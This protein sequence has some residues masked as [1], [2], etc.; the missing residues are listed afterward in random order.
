MN[1]DRFLKK[2]FIEIPDLG[3]DPARILV[4]HGGRGF[5]LLLTHGNPDETSYWFSK[6]FD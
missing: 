5:P 4:R 6:F 2:E 3:F 1:L